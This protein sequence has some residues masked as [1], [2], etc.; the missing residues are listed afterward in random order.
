MPPPPLLPAHLTSA[1]NLFRKQ[2]LKTDKVTPPAA[3]DQQTQTWVF[4]LSCFLHQVSQLAEMSE[5]QRAEQNRKLFTL[6][7]SHFQ[8]Y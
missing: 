8:I 3:C 7:T 2:D 1:Q 6:Q 5:I 4:L